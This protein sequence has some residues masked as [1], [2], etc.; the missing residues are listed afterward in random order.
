[1][2]LVVLV[3][4]LAPS[5][6]VANPEADTARAAA[7]LAAGIRA[8]DA[9]AVAS[10]FGTS[11]TNGG[12][13]FADAACAREFAEPSEITGKRLTLFARCLARHRVQLSTRVSALRNG[14]VLTVEPGIELEVRFNGPHLRWIGHP[15]HPSTG[16]IIP[17]LTAQAFEALRAKGSPNLDAALSPAAL[18]I[19]PS[20]SVSAWLKICLDAQGTTTSVDV[21]G[22][23]SGAISKAFTA[24]VA[25]WAFRPFEI[26]GA[27]I[28]VCSL[29][30]V[31]YPAS[32]APAT[33][34]LPATSVPVAQTTVIDLDDLEDLDLAG[35]FGPPPV[36]P[37]QQAVTPIALERLRL[38]GTKQI[39]P[40]ATTRGQMI[41]AGKLSVLASIKLCVNVR[42]RVAS[43]TL[44]KPSGFPDYDA[45]LL[46]EVRTWTFKPY[47]ISHNPV[48]VCTTTTFFVVPDPTM[49]N[50]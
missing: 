31:T 42:G 18:G 19:A 7:T 3:A 6:A 21:H 49:L 40:D 32:R 23:A 44:H 17:T 41:G 29:S 15:L 43:A 8:H 34:I 50:P 1:V 27:A 28:P 38:T 11:F 39:E 14:A 9:R 2:R 37:V 4:V 48:E 24:A 16:A 46:R 13:W 5:L 22:V 30:H 36:G 25:D 33:E 45:K 26:H 47:L 10:V 35:S 12:V 20:A